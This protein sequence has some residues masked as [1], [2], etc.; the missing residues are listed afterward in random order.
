MLFVFALLLATPPADLKTQ[1]EPGLRAIRGEAL[2]AHIR[3]LADDLLEGR[4]TGTRGHAIAARYLA[5]QLQALGLEPA[6]E[7]GTFF[8]EVP[9]IGMTVQPE[10]CA[11]EID[12]TPLRYGENVLL[13]PRAG[14]AG[15]DVSGELVFA[16]YGI[17]APE[18]GYE[19][20][21]KDLRGKIA[22][23]LIGA[24]RSDRADFFPSAASAVYSDG[25]IKSR[26]LAQRGA[27]GM[28]VVFTPDVAKHLPFPFF[29]RQAPFES[30]V[31]RQG[32]APGTGAV[33][34]SALLPFTEL[35]RLLAKTGGKAEEIFAAGPAGKLKPFPLALRGHLRTSAALR[36]FSSEN[37]VAVLRGSEHAREHV[38]VSAHLDHLGIGPP[39][40]GDSIYNGAVDNASGVSAAI[41]V[42]RAF[43]ALPR[44]PARSIMLLGVTGEEKG[45]QG[46]DYFA[47]SPTVPLESIVADVNI[48]GVNILW[49]PHDMVV[50]GAEHSTLQSAVQAALAAQGLKQSP[51]PEPEQVFFIRSDQYSFVRRGVPAVFPWSGWQDEN[52]NIEKN[53]ALADWWTKNRYH[54]PSDEWDPKGNYQGMAKLVRADFLMALAVALDPERPRWNEGDVFGK[55]FTR[56]E[57]APEG[58]AHGAPR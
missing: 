39:I 23:V 17:S 53:R 6:G 22:V 14:S 54:L 55:L 37:V 18:Y 36:E 51:D 21:P 50:M 45:L 27:V 25:V 28:I 32:S 47:Q 3:F 19:D 13:R 56:R 57:S 40:G 41:E 46:S 12:G 11:L 29:V 31:W 30:M 2:S 9:L 16:G 42:A 43:A 5:T 33:L 48:D 24:P 8:Q 35:Q 26:L 49:E 20:A 34:P 44:R 52:G 58:G 7:R 15:D 1:G 4:G 10:K 38:V